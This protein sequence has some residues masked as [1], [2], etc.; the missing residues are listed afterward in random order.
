VG[1]RLCWKSCSAC[2]FL[3]FHQRTEIKKDV[4]INEWIGQ[5]ESI[6]A[7]GMKE[8]FF[9]YTFLLFRDNRVFISF[10]SL[11]DRQGDKEAF[12]ERSGNVWRWLED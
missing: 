7:T 12:A 11:K 5:V 10:V 8:V 1:F 3:L 6:K 2:W 9:C 4:F